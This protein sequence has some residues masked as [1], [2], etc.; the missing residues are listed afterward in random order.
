MSAVTA[1]A[2][3]EVTSR[4]RKRFDRVPEVPLRPPSFSV[5]LTLFRVYMAWNHWM[6]KHYGKFT[7]DGFNEGCGRWFAL[8]DEKSYRHESDEKGAL[9]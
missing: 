6:M 8:I 3:S 7:G 1:R 4:E 9:S 5:S 2:T